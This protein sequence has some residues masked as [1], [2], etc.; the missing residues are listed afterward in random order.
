[1]IRLA[2]VALRCGINLN[3]QFAPCAARRR[4]EVLMLNEA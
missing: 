4:G 1:M 2:I 3:Y